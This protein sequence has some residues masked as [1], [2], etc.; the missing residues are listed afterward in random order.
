[1]GRSGPGKVVGKVVGR[2]EGGERE[3]GEDGEEREE[4]EENEEKRKKT[5]GKIEDGENKTQR[6]FVQKS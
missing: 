4:N 2:R 3:D 5:K 6:M 1:M